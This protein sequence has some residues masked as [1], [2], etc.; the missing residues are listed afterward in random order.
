[1]G[2]LIENMAASHLHALGEQ[3]Q[4]RLYYWRDKNDEIDLIYDH[5][6]HPVAFEVARSSSHHRRGIAAFTARYPRFEGRCY[7][8]SENGNLS[9]PHDNWDHI[10]TI[11]LDLFLLI[12]GS[13]AEKELAARLF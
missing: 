2:L 12:V 9:R 6:D 5:P 1:M 7:L 3:S 11:P 8:I 13:Q 4:T 10:G